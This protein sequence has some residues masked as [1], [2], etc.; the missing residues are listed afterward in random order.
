RRPGLAELWGSS[1]EAS[2]QTPA[3]GAGWESSLADVGFLS[4]RF[5]LGADVRE[6][7]SYGLQERNF[8]QFFGLLCDKQN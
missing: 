7:A 3:C 5:L 4:A 2:E 1:S 6:P 8:R